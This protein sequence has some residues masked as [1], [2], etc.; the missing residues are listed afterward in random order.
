MYYLAVDIGA[1]SGRHIL[2]ETKDGKMLLTEVYRFDNN[3]VEKNGHTCWDTEELFTNILEGMKKCNEL[4]KTPTSMAIDTWGV[5]FVLLNNKL[6][7]ISDTVAYRDSRTDKMDE[8]CEAM[9]PFSEHYERT[10]IQ[11]NVFNTAYQLLALK[12]ENPEVLNNAEHFLLMPEYFNFLLTG[13]VK[14]E[15]T[16]STTTALV[17]AKTKTWDKELIE[18]IG[19][20]S[21]IFGEI[22]M[23][24]TL[25]GNLKEDISEL[26][27]FDTAV[28]L[29]ASHDTGSA[30]LAVPAKDENAV[31]I[32]SGTWSLL[33]VENLEPLTDEKSRINMFT[34]EGGYDYRYRYLKNIMG[35]WIIQSVRRNYDKKYSFAQLEAMARE[36]SGFKGR[37]DVNDK[38]FLAPKSMV[39]A[40]TQMATIKPQNIGQLMECIYRSL[41]DSYKNAIMG[42]EKAT[43]KKFTSIN[44]V[45]GGSKDQYLNS[46][47]MEVTGLPVYAG[48]T[49]G[50]ALGNLMCQMIRNN[51]FSDLQDARNAVRRSFDIIS[52]K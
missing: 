40:V 4:G 12:I 21:K 19:I 17:G 34:N 2:C 15:Y 36:E 28:V 41:A 11:K 51:E 32:S 20:P 22:Y 38:A 42:M 48:P 49:E 23:P 13:I 31:Y 30:F 35:L 1:S 24:K 27:G 37:I 43:G 25:V 50:T 16:N 46:L 44:I 9:V 10:G 18:K 3:L 14:N 39:E 29:A 7:R 47:A 33:G 52:Y 5:D 45:G 6:E 8:V 26:V